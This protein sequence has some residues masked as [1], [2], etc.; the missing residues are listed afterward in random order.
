[1]TVTDYVK[2]Y[3][4]PAGSVYRWVKEGRLK[5]KKTLI[6][7]LDVEDKKIEKKPRYR[8]LPRYKNAI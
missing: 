8:L 1:M 7:R 2:K 4:V 3:R 6:E 5:A